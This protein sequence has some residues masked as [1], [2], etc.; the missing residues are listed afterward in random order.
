MVTQQIPQRT[1]QQILVEQA[2]Q[3]EPEAIAALLNRPENK[4]PFRLQVRRRGGEYR[5]L[6]EADQLPDQQAT[7]RWIMR[8]LKKLAIAEMRT[9][10][11]YGKSRQSAKPDWQ[12]RFEIGPEVGQFSYGEAPP[13]PISASTALPALEVEPPLDLSEYCFIRNLSLLSV[14]LTPPGKAVTQTVLSFVALPDAQKLAVLPHFTELLQKPEP[15]PDDALAPESH[16]WIT[17]ILAL[18]GDNL[19]KLSIWLSRYC[20]NPTATVELLKPIVATSK[21]DSEQRQTPAVGMA[22][23]PDVARVIAVQAARAEQL[24]SPEPFSQSSWLPLW[25]V[26]T[27]WT[28]GLLLAITL[29]ISSAN[30]ADASFPICKQAT[31]AA[32]CTLAVQLASDQSAIASAMKAAAPITPEIKA[33]AA[34]QCSEYGST[35]ILSALKLSG[36]A[37]PSVE[38][39]SAV[40]LSKSQTT[41]LFPGVLL[42][43]ITQTDSSAN[44]RTTRIAC[45][46]YVSTAPA[47]NPLEQTGEAPGEPEAAIQEIAADEIPL[48][49]P[50]EPYEKTTVMGSSPAKAL[51]TY[52]L[53]INFSANTLFTAIGL[54]VAVLLYACYSCYTLKGIYQMALPLGVLETIMHIVPAIGL[55][56]SVPLGVGAIGLTSRFVKDFNIIWSDGYKPLAR[57]AVTIVVIK[58]VLMWALYS[59]IAHLIV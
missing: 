12:Q 57:G 27:A 47:A 56:V 37:L 55:F 22:A 34:E 7:V 29:G 42:T 14:D 52:D 49:W 26:P 33:A 21:D 19:R 46:G 8:A 9:V 23:N 45:V 17:E 24:H 20:A 39:G 58:V 16:A 15:L 18:E 44:N 53:F 30:S 28:A 1:P 11:I 50:E 48:S 2:K 31:D 36:L 6:A 43:D 54:F 38:D 10:T 35:H 5:L 13:T 25:V 4:Q 32:Q 59:A 40:N 41:E 51:G 3:G